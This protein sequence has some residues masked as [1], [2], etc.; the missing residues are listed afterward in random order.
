MGALNIKEDATSIGS[1]LSDESFPR[2]APMSMTDTHSIVQAGIRG[3]GSDFSLEDLDCPATSI[4]GRRS[5]R[6]SAAK[7]TI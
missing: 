7:V 2:G 5:Y 4:V 6:L 3:V 1:S